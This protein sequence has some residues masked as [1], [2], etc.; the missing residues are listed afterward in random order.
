[1]A[2]LTLSGTKIKQFGEH[3][4]RREQLETNKKQTIVYKTPRKGERIKQKKKE[5]QKSRTSGV[6]R[7]ASR[8][9]TGHGSSVIG[10]LARQTKI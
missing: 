7:T 5:P 1:M 3:I 10:S 2:R 6:P 9:V 4:R 8:K